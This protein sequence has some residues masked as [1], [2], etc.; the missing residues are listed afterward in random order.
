MVGGSGCS[1]HCTEGNIPSKHPHALAEGVCLATTSQIMSA[2]SGE[3][4]SGTGNYQ[5][6]VDC[7]IVIKP[8]N[9]AK[10]ELIL[11]TFTRCAID[12]Y[13]Y[14]TDVVCTLF[15][16]FA[17]HPTRKYEIPVDFLHKTGQSVRWRD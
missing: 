8:A 10:D 16:R 7:S 2:S 5:N 6:N 15:A 3:L 1:A 11:L 17:V 14:G 13:R 4:S 12:P 9:L